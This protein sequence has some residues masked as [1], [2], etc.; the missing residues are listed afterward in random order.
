MNKYLII[1]HAESPHILKWVKGL[2]PHFDLYIISSTTTHQDIREML[3]PD[4][5]FDLNLRQREGSGNV[6]LLFKYF[7]IKHFIRKIKPDVINAHYITSHGLLAALVKKFS[8][9]NFVLVQ[10]AWGSDI[11]VTPFR[12]AL[13]GKATRFLLRSAD[14]VTC[15]SKRMEELIRQWTKVRVMNFTFGLLSIPEYSS[16]EKDDY[17]FYSN[18]HLSANYNIEEV[19]K[20]FS[21]IAQAEDRARL[22]VANDG[23]GRTKLEDIVK[24]LDLERKV[25]FTGLIPEEEQIPNYRNARFYISIPTSDSIS[26][27]VMEAMAHGCIPVLSDLEGNREMVRDTENGILYKPGITT[28]GDVLKMLD[29]KEEIAIENREL[30]RKRFL[31]TDSISQYASEVSSLISKKH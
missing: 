4:H 19:I 8:S 5:I 22:V 24:N 10:S 3:G 21:R 26:V 28:A 9:L 13:Y 18:R 31:F 30:I 27:S 14:L 11:L 7:K 12:N 1:G 15:D 20:L 17:L 6:N 29:R 23:P 2:V 25:T 16:E